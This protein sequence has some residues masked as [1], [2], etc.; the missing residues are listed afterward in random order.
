MATL[1]RRT[2]AEGWTVEREHHIADALL[3]REGIQVAS[4]PLVSN[5]AGRYVQQF[6]LSQP[7]DYLVKIEANNSH[8]RSSKFVRVLPDETRANTIWIL[9]AVIV[10]ISLLFA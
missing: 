6:Q 1:E 4:L 3:F 2:E 5:A 7:G 8:L 9:C 10:A